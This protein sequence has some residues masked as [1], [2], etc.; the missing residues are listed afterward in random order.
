V[1]AAP[2]VTRCGSAAP[3]ASVL[4]ESGSVDSHLGGPATPR[5]DEV[6]EDQGFVLPA[7]VG[8]GPHG[9]SPAHGPT[10]LLH[11]VVA[12]PDF[13]LLGSEFGARH[14][15]AAIASTIDVSFGRG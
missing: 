1:T 10:R 15:S 11:L 14:F 3:P 12:S 6:N 9:G 5:V 7:A 4:A 8:K 2:E 13:G